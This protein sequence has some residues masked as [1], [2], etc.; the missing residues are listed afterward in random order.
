MTG[1]APLF[2]VESRPPG[3]S[4]SEDHPRSTVLWAWV[5]KPADLRGGANPAVSSWVR[6]RQSKDPF[7]PGNHVA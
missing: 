3:Y 7:C 4:K 5:G 6:V 2:L 1:M